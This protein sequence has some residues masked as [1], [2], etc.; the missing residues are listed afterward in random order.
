MLSNQSLTHS[1]NL[2]INCQKIFG[3]ECN[4]QVFGFDR[5]TSL[6]P[7]IDQNYVFDQSTTTAILA[8]LMFNQNTLL[9]GMHGTGKSTHIEQVCARLNWQV[10][11]INFDSQITRLD[12]VGKDIITLKDGN[13]AHSP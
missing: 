2:E 3:F 10:L 11:R 13:L 6:V 12:L 8:G 4:F 5:T 1:P 7:A 9:Q